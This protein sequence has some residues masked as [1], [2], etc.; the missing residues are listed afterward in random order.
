[1]GQFL[2][3]L[4]RTPIWDNLLVVVYADH[5]HTYGLTF[6]NPE[7]FH[8]PLFLVG[9]AVSKCKTYETIIAQ[10]DIAATI[11]SQLGIPHNE[12][13]PWSRNVFSRNYTYPFAYCCYPAGALLVDES[14]KT[15]IDVQSGYIMA[16]EPQNS[17][18][19]LHN[20]NV[21]LQKSYDTIPQSRD[22]Q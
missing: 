17:E 7:F 6:D 8:M 1:V 11:L 2:D 19:R 5:G 12:E 21:M 4:S 22:N 16:D 3:S 20:I 14:G 10:N 13:F 15:M 18:T 9:G